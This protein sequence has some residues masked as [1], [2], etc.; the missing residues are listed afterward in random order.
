M[1]LTDEL[2]KGNISN[3]YLI[4][5]PE[6]YKRKVA[7]EALKSNVPFGDKINYSYYE[8]KN[9]DF[10]DVCEKAATMPFFADKRLIIIENSGRFKAKKKDNDNEE[11]ETAAADSMIDKIL[12]NIPETTVLVFLEEAAAKNKKIYKAISKSGF[13][14][15]CEPDTGDVLIS[16]IM[17]YLDK[18]G[19]KISASGANS[20]VARVGADYNKINNELEKIISYTGDSPSVTDADINAVCSEDIESRIFDMLDSMGRKNPKAALEKYY[21]LLSNREPA[22]YILAMI[23]KQY[24][25]MLESAELGN[26][27]MNEKQVAGATGTHPYSVGKAMDFMRK[28]YKRKDVI[29]ILNM[30]NDT[31]FRIKNG[32]IDDRTGVEA[33]IVGIASN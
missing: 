6:A 11:E 21:V 3:V 33:L 10:N 29:R 9:I 25:L 28:Y 19:K 5:G 14:E 26:K 8:G 32:D 13:V 22:L 27:R 1:K 20:I 24:R 31:D 7:K 2:K 17:G 4:Y 18:N 16:Y 23:R 30:I 12:S 15:S